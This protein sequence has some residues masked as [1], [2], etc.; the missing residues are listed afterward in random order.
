MRVFKPFFEELFDHSKVISVSKVPFDNEVRRL[1]E[2]NMCGNYAKSWTCPPAIDSI[3]KLQSRLSVFK[4]FLIFYKVYSLD[5]SFDWQGMMAGVKDFQLKIFKF[6]KKILHQYPW[7]KFLFL[8]AGSCQLCN[9]CTYPQ[10][11]P[12]KHPEDALFSIESFGIDAMKM[13]KDNGLKYN[14][15]LNTVTYIGGLFYH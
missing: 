15:G 3:E 5:D 1:C 12:C 14:N 9:A 8:G 10:Q 4:Y 6:K 7:L 13:M 11:K 2:Q